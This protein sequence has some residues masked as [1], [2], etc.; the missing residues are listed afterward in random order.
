M[1]SA[2]MSIFLY[3]IGHLSSDIH[4]LGVGGYTPFVTFVLKAL[5]YVLPNLEKFNISAVVVHGLPLGAGSV[6]FSVTY[7]I[8]YVAFLLFLAATFLKQFLV[9]NPDWVHVDLAAGNHKGGLAHVPSDVT[10]FGVRWTLEL[11]NDRK[12]FAKP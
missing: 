9:G 4:I 8:A 1:I 2:M 5:Y 10:G 7:G 3:I 11:L 12:V 6:L